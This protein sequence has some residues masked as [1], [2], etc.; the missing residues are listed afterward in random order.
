M[1]LLRVT[2]LMALFISL[3]IN[4]FAG[5]FALSG[6]GSRAISMGGAFRGLAD[7]PSAMYWNPAGLG[8]VNETSISL[9]GTFI[10]PSA[11]WNNNGPI[12]PNI[13]GYQAQKYEAQSSLRIFPNAF[14]T[15]VDH[16]K[17]KYGLGMFVPYGLGSTWDAYKP[18]A[19]LAGFND[20]PENEMLSSIAIIDVHPSFAY[21]LMPRLSL[22][23]GLSV[24]YGMIDLAKAQYA[25]SPADTAN[26]IPAM[27]IPTTSDLSGTGIGFGGNLGLLFK[28]TSCLSIGLSGRLPSAIDMKGEIEAFTWIPPTT[29][30]GGISDIQTTLKLPAEAGIGF[31]Y[32]VKP[33][34]IVNLDYSYTLWD[35]LDKVVVDLDTPLTV[36]PDPSEPQLTSSEVLFNWENTSRISFGTEYEMSCNKLRAGFYMDQSPIPESTQVITLSDIGNKFS[37]NLGLGRRFGPLDLDL[38][39]QYVYFPE[40][41]VTQAVTNMGGIY[42]ANSISGNIGLTFRF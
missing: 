6:I 14:F 10:L 9:G 28:P 1:K 2:L 36:N 3:S 12:F 17:L 30:L 37:G 21:Q 8:F 29:K 11:S 31:S 33:N 35:R 32:L 24:Y 4:L 18:P 27:Y 15:K 22:G 39:F 13:D 16:P 7:D 26:A 40:R 41:K 5:G 38:N 42:N 19:Y 34:W 25:Y 23:A 20:F